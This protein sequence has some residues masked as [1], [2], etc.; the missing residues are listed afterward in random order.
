M[1]RRIQLG[2]AGLRARL[3]RLEPVSTLAVGGPG[4]RPLES[5]RPAPDSC[6]SGART[7][8]ARSPARAR[9]WP[10]GPAP[11]D[12]QNPP[13]HVDELTRGAPR[14]A[15][16]DGQGRRLIKALDDRI[17]RSENLAGVRFSAFGEGRPN[18]PDMAKPPAPTAMQDLSRENPRVV[19]STSSFRAVRHCTSNTKSRNVSSA[20]DEQ[21]PSDHVLKWR[22][23][24]TQTPRGLPPRDAGVPGAAAR[25][26]I[27][28]PHTRT[29]WSVKDVLGHLWPAT[30]NRA[31]IPAHRA[32]A[33]RP[34]STVR[35]W[36]R[37]SLQRANR[38]PRAR[39]GLRACSAGWSVARAD[40]VRRFRRLPTESLRDPSH[41]TP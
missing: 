12:V 15:G 23:D 20:P 28:R 3:D 40:V 5:G 19:I 35:S 6:R 26:P 1:R 41:A 32:G 29:V 9:P 21:Q 7:A 14:L 2:F 27:L 30:R 13:H 10:L 33:R 16:N 17:E 8:P 37:R 25:A 24:A 22:R 4:R 36:R 39:L 31:P 11:F 38:H 34:H 18:R